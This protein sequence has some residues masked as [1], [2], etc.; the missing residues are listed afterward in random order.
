M[1]RIAISNYLC[2]VKAIPN[3][4][5]EAITKYP[6][7]TTQSKATND[8][9]IVSWGYPPKGQSRYIVVETGFFWDGTHLDPNGLYDK[10]SLNTVNGIQAVNDY[11][12]PVSAYDVIKFSGIP[13]SKYRQTRQ[14]IIWDGVVLAS[15][16]PK[17][18]SVTS[19]GTAEDYWRFFESAC[20][21]Y[22]KRLF[23]K[24]HPHN[25]GNIKER[26]RDIATSHGCSIAKCNHKCLLKCEFVLI[27]NSTF[28][29]DCFVRGVP[30]VQY[31]PGYFHKTGAVT[32]TNGT[33]VKV[34]SNTI[35][36][37]YK[38]VDFL[39]WR[40]C[41]NLQQPI[42]RWIEMLRAVS[43]SNDQFPLPAEFGYA[44]NLHWSH[45]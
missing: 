29:V 35:S 17:D 44:E 34:N 39:I 13:N 32:F 4:T 9:L 20:K 24:L 15:Q 21:F 8:D 5:Y 31:A 40:Y 7:I 45:K 23:I 10:S 36:R 1:N 3:V 42:D 16:N 12:A 19:V 30:V 37:A 28:A 25:T 6:D 38:L 14:D 43:R 22:G 41:F 26:M 33:F 2:R 27:Y 11:V 18:R